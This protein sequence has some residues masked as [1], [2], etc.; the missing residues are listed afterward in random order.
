L[1]FLYKIVVEGLIK[2]K[3]SSAVYDS[4][5][6]ASDIDPI[7]NHSSDDYLIHLVMSASGTTNSDSR[8]YGGSGDL[9]LHNV[10]SQDINEASASL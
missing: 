1:E 7:A 2:E 8:I 6:P 3:Q 5:L 10:G 4:F 9:Y